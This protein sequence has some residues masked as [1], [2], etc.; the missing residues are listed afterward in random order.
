MVV[1]KINGYMVQR[2]RVNETEGMVVTGGLWKYNIWVSDYY[3]LEC[4]QVTR[5][6][7]V[8]VVVKKNERDRNNK[9]DRTDLNCRE[10]NRN[11]ICTGV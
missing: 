3:S 5:E 8:T 1:Y 2:N 7:I 9:T 11:K 4:T 6:T 10:Y